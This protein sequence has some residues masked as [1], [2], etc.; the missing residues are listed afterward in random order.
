MQL[1]LEAL[2]VTLRNAWLINRACAP[3]AL[4]TAEGSGQV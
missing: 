2:A 1:H 3:T 4:W